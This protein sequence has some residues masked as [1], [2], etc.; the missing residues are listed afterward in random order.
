MARKRQYEYTT[1]WTVKRAAEKRGIGSPYELSQRLSAI[2]YEKARKLWNGEGAL[3]PAE[4]EAL[5]R[6]LNCGLN[7]LIK[8][9]KVLIQNGRQQQPAKG[10]GEKEDFLGK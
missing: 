6:F 10:S 3:S 9:N 7:S 4:I 2:T 8:R 5:R 1:V